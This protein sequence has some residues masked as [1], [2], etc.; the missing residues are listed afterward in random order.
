MFGH[1]I[2]NN[3]NIWPTSETAIRDRRLV[4]LPG[5]QATIHGTQGISE[6][7]LTEAG[8]H[9]LV[10]SLAGADSG[11]PPNASVSATNYPGQTVNKK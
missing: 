3:N 4:T 2:H 8:L 7:A 6:Y 9:Q 5:V 11:L 1:Q 10:K